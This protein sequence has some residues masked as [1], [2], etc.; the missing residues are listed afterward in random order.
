MVEEF[1]YT[2]QSETPVQKAQLHTEPSPNPPCL[3]LSAAWTSST[4]LSMDILLTLR[5]ASPNIRE[6]FP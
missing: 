5:V 3:L 2:P 4:P 1:I 6:S